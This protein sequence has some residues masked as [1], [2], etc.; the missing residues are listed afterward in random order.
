MNAVEVKHVQEVARKN[1]YNY[2]LMNLELVRSEGL[3]KD[4]LIYCPG[5]LTLE[6]GTTLLTIIII[7][8]INII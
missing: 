3:T 5:I 4:S 6:N 8:I 1:K 2:V 7:I